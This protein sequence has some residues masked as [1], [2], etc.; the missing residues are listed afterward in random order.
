[1]SDPVAR[2]T[3]R[4]ERTIRNA[5]NPE[6]Q[7]ERDREPEVQ[8]FSQTSTYQPR[9]LPRNSSRPEGDRLHYQRN[10]DDG[11]RLSAEPSLTSRQ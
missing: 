4:I 11:S 2:A 6:Q 9:S 7:N 1:M 10:I 8:A 3:Q 5:A